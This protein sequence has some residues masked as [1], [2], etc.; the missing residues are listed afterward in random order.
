MKKSTLAKI[1]AAGVLVVLTVVLA[2]TVNGGDA[3]NGRYYATVVALLPPVIAIVLALI[4]KEVY[5][6]LFI[7]ILAGALFANG[8]RPVEALNSIIGEGL[9]SA[10]EGNAGIFLFLIMLGILVAL[11]NSTGAAAAFGRW[12]ASP[13]TTRVGA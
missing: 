3:E 6:S 1:I 4:T 5:S 11:V 12:A 2:I 10:V 7:G 8:F 13:I 9:T